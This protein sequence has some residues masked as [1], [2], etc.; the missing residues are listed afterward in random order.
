MTGRE[1]LA[2]T[3]AWAKEALTGAGAW[4]TLHRQFTP[5][6]MAIAALGGVVVGALLF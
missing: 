3:G 6:H 4:C 2:A 1:A 5:C